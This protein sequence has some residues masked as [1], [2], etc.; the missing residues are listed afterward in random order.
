MFVYSGVKPV[1]AGLVFFSSAIGLT[2][3]I[4]AV[5]AGFLVTVEQVVVEALRVA[6]FGDEVVLGSVY[7]LGEVFFEPAEDTV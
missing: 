5:T 2:V 3:V 1:V 7:C 6:V 4:V